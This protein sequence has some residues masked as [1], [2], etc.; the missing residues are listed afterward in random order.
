MTLIRLTEL[1]KVYNREVQPVLALKNINLK[2]EPGELLAIM[3]PSGSGKSTLMHILGCLDTPSRGQYFLEDKDISSLSRDDLA[4][5]RNEKIG[6]VFQQFFLLPRLNALENVELPLLYTKLGTAARRQRVREVMARL[7]LSGREHHLPAQL[8]G[9]QQQRVA[10]A[11]A[12]I[13]DPLLLL[14]DEPTGNLDTATSLEI[15]AIFQELNTDRGLTIVLVTHDPE[16]A[17]FTQRQLSIRDGE[18]IADH[19]SRAES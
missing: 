10:I 13:N 11:R 19:H 16:M 5:I 4:R 12:L 15:M 17:G 9:G 1:S 7:G 8:S 3:G 18:I 6:F 14:T 2:I